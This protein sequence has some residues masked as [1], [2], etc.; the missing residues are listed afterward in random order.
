MTGIEPGT[1]YPNPRSHEG[2]QGRVVKLAGGSKTSFDLTMEI[3]P[4]AD[5]VASAEKAA[6]AI[7]GGRKP[8]MHERPLK[9]WCAGL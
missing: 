9:G 4:T 3:H 2:E 8:M 7:A 6:T 1:N 5:D